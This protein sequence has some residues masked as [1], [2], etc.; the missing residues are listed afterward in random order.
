MRAKGRNLCRTLPENEA[1][2]AK[3]CTSS[4]CPAAEAPI[5]HNQLVDRVGRATPLPTP[6]AN[7]RGTKALLL[8]E[9]L[10][11]ATTNAP[12]NCAKRAFTEG[13][14]CV[15]GV[16]ADCITTIWRD[17]DVAGTTS[18]GGI[19]NRW[20][21]YSICNGRKSDC[22]CV[23]RRRVTSRMSS[24][25]AGRVPEGTRLWIAAPAGAVNV[26]PFLCKG[27]LKAAR[28]ATEAAAIAHDGVKTHPEG[29]NYLVNRS[30]RLAGRTRGLP[31]SRTTG[32]KHAAPT[33]VAPDAATILPNIMVAPPCQGGGDSAGGTRES[34]PDPRERLEASVAFA[35]E[36]HSA[37][38]L[39]DSVM[40]A[41]IHPRVAWPRGPSAGLSVSRY[42]VG[43]DHPVNGKSGL[44]P[45]R[46]LGCQG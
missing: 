27:E 16:Q 10:E 12:A 34:P 32:S 39:G 24:G 28:S 25:A 43:N 8:A 20:R 14:D 22:D 19:R 1:P 31:K 40:G 7:R 2:L 3:R 29:T 35:A 5:I 41:V 18:P 36:A 44:L 33:A 13:P 21:R 46:N 38:S 9:L 11:A 45:G 23:T 6:W 26:V 30:F 15:Q 42:R 37:A 4:A 17:A